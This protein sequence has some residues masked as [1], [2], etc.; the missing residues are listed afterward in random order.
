M[1]TKK[2]EKLPS[3][4]RVKDHFRNNADNMG[5]DARKPVLG[6]LRSLISTFVIRLL[7]SI[8]SRL[9]TSA[10]SSF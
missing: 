4:Q 7:E 2:H 3:M 9:A 1:Q 5:R 6:G 10:I 8:I